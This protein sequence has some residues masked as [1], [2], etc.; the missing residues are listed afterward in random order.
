MLVDHRTYTVRPGTLALQLA[1][2]ERYGFEPQ[3][4]HLGDPVAYLV[5]E[6]GDPNSYVHLWVYRDAADRVR[7]REALQADPAWSAYAEKAYAAGYIVKQETKLM[8]DRR[9][10][11]HIF[12]R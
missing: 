12:S 9:R 6:S 10:D 11:N 3:R 5:T 4:R 8:I 7:R 1:L 2:Y